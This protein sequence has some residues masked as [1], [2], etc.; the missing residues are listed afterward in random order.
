M[1]RPLALI[2]EDHH[3]LSIVFAQAVEEAGFETEIVRSGDKALERLAATVPDF[4]LLD[5]HLP[6]VLGTEIL[7]QIRADPRLAKTRVA[8]ITAYQNLARA[9]KGEADWILMKPIT[10]GQLRELAAGIGPDAS[11][12]SQQEQAAAG[13]DE[14]P[15]AGV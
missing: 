9:V 7:R 10:F 3:N 1:D 6:K 4:V 5:L 14:R 15:R 13:V 12:Y 11:L 8:V 2:V